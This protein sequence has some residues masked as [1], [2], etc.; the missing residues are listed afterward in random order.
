MILL[1]REIKKAYKNGDVRIEP[2]NE[3]NLAINSIDVTMGKFL[4]TY[5]PLKI[6][7][8]KAGKVVVKDKERIKQMDSYIPE[9]D[10]FYI[11]MKK[12]NETFTIEIPEEGLILNTDILYLGATNEKAGSDKFIPMYEGRSSL[13][14]L[15]FESH[16]SAGF[17]DLGFKSNW[18]LEITVTQPLKVYPNKR[19]GQVY[20]L[21]ADAEEVELAM[22]ESG[23]YKGKYTD[24]PLPQS[25]KSYKDFE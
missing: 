1:A 18:T 21:K 12:D 5:V 8:T 19:V 17:G 2:Y 3:E 13:A 22:Q 24:Q 15:G 16:K 4:V 14:R 25:S 23:E 10:N 11:D 9:I 6:I 20:F 7:D